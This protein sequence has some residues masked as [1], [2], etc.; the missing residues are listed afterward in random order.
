M[1]WKRDRWLWAA[2]L[3]GVVLRIAPRALWPM[4][5]CVRDECTYMKLATRMAE[6]E[7]MTA[8]AGWL[9]APGWPALMGLF[10][11]MTGFSGLVV[12]LSIVVA[13]A[14]SV[15]LYQLAH[16]LFADLEPRLKRTT[17]LVAAW[18]YAISLHQVFFAQR[19]WS[20]V[21]YTGVLLT[22]LLLF[23]RARER[24]KDGGRRAALLA[25]AM[26]GACVGV[27]VLFRGVAQYMLPIFVVGLV[28]GRL[29][30]GVVYGQ[31]AA[32]VV[33]AVL[34]V[35]PY[36]V[37][38]TQ[39]HGSFVLSDRTL[40]QMMWLGNNDFDPIGFD[41]GNGQ[42]SQ[43]A[44]N[45]TKNK[46]RPKCAKRSNAMELDACQVDAGKQFILDDPGLFVSRMPMRVAQMLTPHSLL[47]R[48]VRW[49]RYPGIGWVGREVL[50][51]LQVIVSLVVMLVGAVGLTTRARGGRGIVIAGILTYHV[52]AIA[53][54]AGI[55]RY[56]VPLEPMLML[57]GAAVFA[58]WEGTKA[59][60]AQGPLR[61]RLVLTV[62]TLAVLTPLVLWNLPA[63]WPEWRHW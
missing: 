25:A 8:S 49:H 41:Y 32:M 61:W 13:G 62:L 1:S 51:L 10:K 24:V 28:W 57:Y 2:I 22:G 37:H 30:Q 56:R 50:V 21:V 11:A 26:L 38:A 47:T 59:A 63:G 5:V 45:R 18:M 19:L 27:M 52:A 31:A 23:V 6:G 12:I 55:S 17:G 20:E 53:A 39:K 4:D 46:G 15:L 36:S 7:G 33:A 42:I 35:T 40:G 60:L 54:L 14:N 34:V 43:R 3:L 16:T 9:W 58:D 48:H 29:R 44:F